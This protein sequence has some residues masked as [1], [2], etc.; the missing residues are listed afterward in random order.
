[1]KRIWE[2]NI[3][4]LILFLLLIGCIHPLSCQQLSYVNPILEIDRPDPTILKD[5]DGIFYLYSTNASK[6]LPIYSSRNLFNWE[7]M[8]E[9]IPSDQV[10]TGLEGGGLWAPDIILHNGKYLL[11][12]S[13]SAAGEYHK[14]GIGLA[15]AEK[16]TGP[17]KNLG[18]LFTSA[19]SGVRNSI[20]PAFIVENGKLYILW[21]SFNG[22]YIVELKQNN[23]GKYFIEN[24]NSKLK[25][26][27]NAFEG[28]HIFKRNK[29]YYLFA[30]VG[31]CCLKDNS[32]YRVVVGRSKN[33][34]GPYVDETGRDMLDNGYNFVVGSNEKFVGPGHGSSII[35]D[36]DGRTW[37]IYHSY[38]RGKSDKGRFPM[39]DE[40]K[41]TKDG[42]PYIYKGAPSTES[43]P[44]PNL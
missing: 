14:N 7:Y 38:V 26:A 10:P 27:G 23:E 25:L 1:M 40:I 17:F 20:D 43:T 22:I 31:R 32:S 35:T 8:G 16:P 13:Y 34:F 12:Y 30:S 24:M 5:E 18:M 9:G 36:K 6:K 3:Y 37:Y 41:W 4:N 29:Y 44:A 19:S 11:A 21:G 33:L 28:A 42:W 15:I 2:R 39:L